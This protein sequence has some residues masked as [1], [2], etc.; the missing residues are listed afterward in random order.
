MPAHPEH[1]SVAERFSYEFGN[2][3]SHLRKYRWAYSIG[4]SAF[5]LVAAAIAW[6]R[7][8]ASATD[9][10]VIFLASIIHLLRGA[11]IVSLLFAWLG[12]KFIQDWLFAR[13]SNAWV[14]KEALRRPGVSFQVPHWRFY[15]PAAMARFAIFG[16]W[17]GSL[18]YS[19]F[20]I[21]SRVPELERFT[22][23]NF[24]F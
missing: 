6:A 1:W 7:T 20:I 12:T 9:L 17:L 11:A 22:P 23:N 4:A 19:L 8:D 24:P 5:V 3:A 14:T 21:P 16:V 13:I 10:P 2:T 15:V 18:F